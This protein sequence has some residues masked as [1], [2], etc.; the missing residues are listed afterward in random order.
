MMRNRIIAVI[1][2]CAMLLAC[3]CA[4]GSDG[5]SG[6]PGQYADDY[7]SIVN[8]KYDDISV[9]MRTSS[10]AYFPGSVISITAVIENNSDMYYLVAP[11]G[12]GFSIELKADG[13]RMAEII[14]ASASDISEALILEP[15]GSVS[16]TREFMTNAIVGG[17]EKPVWECE[18]VAVLNVGISEPQVSKELALA[19]KKYTPKKAETKI[20]IHGTGKKPN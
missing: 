6:T 2:L 17:S 1:A 4:C 19:S 3:F 16:V 14:D 11:Y 5:N 10:S 7:Q 20:A 12:K 13:Y 18:A 9:K 15:N 8:E